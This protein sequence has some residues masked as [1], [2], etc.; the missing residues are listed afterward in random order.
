M[1]FAVLQE[2]LVMGLGA[3]RQQLENLIK[4]DT[5][6]FVGFLLF[7]LSFISEICNES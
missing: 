6:L 1:L 7:K 3:D 4:T 5:D 2:E